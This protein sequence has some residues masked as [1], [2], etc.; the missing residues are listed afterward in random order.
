[1]KG[2]EKFVSLKN[3]QLNFNFIERIENIDKINL[4]KFWICENKIR[5]I[6]NLPKSLTNLW[7]ATNLIQ[8]LDEN[9]TQ[10]DKLKELNLSANLF[11][12]FKDLYILSDLKSLETLN[13]NDPNFGENPIC[14]INNYRLYLLHRMP[15]LKILDEVNIT[16][17]EK[18]EFEL[19]Y[20]KKSTFY[21]NKIKQLNRISKLSF[22]LLKTFSWFFKL[23]KMLQIYF[24]K[25]R[26]KML[27]YI[28]YERVC[29]NLINKT[30]LN[31]KVSETNLDKSI[32]MSS[33]ENQKDNEKNRS[34][35]LSDTHENNKGESPYIYI[36][37]NNSLIENISNDELI[38]EMNKEIEITNHKIKK[39]IS[40][41]QTI[42]NNY[43]LIKKLISEVNDFS[44]IR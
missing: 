36:N 44:I 22:K 16:K 43:F 13:L 19:I 29:Q 1:M 25:K 35:S 11:S 4:E 9:I 26:I 41:F 21:K 28:Q 31:Q 40:N 8:K 24:F 30:S 42:D 34:I 12:S 38:E 23:M 32:N 7:V 39:C 2:I 15:N 5:R 6:E 10:Y 17:E 18:D 33:L 37:Y 20:L 14:L 3:L 27:Q